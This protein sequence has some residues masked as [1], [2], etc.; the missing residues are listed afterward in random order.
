MR[1]LLAR[2]PKLKNL[3]LYAP[4]FNQWGLFQ[5]D[6]LVITEANHESLQLAL[7]SITH[8]TICDSSINDVHFRNLLN[9]LPNLTSLNTMSMYFQRMDAN[10]DERKY[11]SR[12]CLIQW[13][14]Y[15]GAGKLTELQIK[16]VDDDLLVNLANVERLSLKVCH[17]QLEHVEQH[18]LER[19]LRSQPR[20]EDFHV[21]FTDNTS[22]KKTL[23]LLETVPCLKEIKMDVGLDTGG[24]ATVHNMQHLEVSLQISFLKL[25]INVSLFHR[26]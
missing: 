7:N 10:A 13:L 16:H 2:C 11:L 8:L 19:F 4:C 5:K 6:E 3:Q 18:S 12:R 14:Q 1:D 17:L 9:N 22:P 21:Q 15:R 23:P 26:N 25:L 24:F 20:L